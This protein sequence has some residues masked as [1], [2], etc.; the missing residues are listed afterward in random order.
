MSN[1]RKLPPAIRAPGAGPQG[2]RIA[3]TAISPEALATQG[4]PIQGAVQLAPG[5]ARAPRVSA[6][7]DDVYSIAKMELRDLKSKRFA[8]GLDDDEFSRFV[9]I[10]ERLPAMLREERAQDEALLDVVKKMSQE[11]VDEVVRDYIERNGIKE[12]EE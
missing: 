8:G 1:D 9:K 10:M 2:T 12:P 7:L 11:D 4:R 5:L 3:P 6:L